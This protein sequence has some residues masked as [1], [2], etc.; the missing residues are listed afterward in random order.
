[1]PLLAT[2]DVFT[3]AE[4]LG[5]LKAHE[6]TGHLHVRTG[7]MSANL[8][9]E[10]GWLVGVDLGDRVTGGGDD[11]MDAVLEICCEL[12]DS[13][14]GVSEFTPS[15]ATSPNG[16]RFDTDALLDSAR[17]RLE[18]W[19][20]I[21]AAIPS[22]ELKPRLATTLPSQTITLDQGRWQLILAVDGRRS[23]ASI[24]RAVGL[25]S[26]ELRRRMKALVDDRIIELDPALPRVPF[27][28][29]AVRGDQPPAEQ[30]QVGS[31]EEPPAGEPPADSKTARRRSWRRRRKDEA[32]GETPEVAEGTR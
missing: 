26:Y 20:S 25:T 13:H 16:V 17:G 1:M 22:V 9:L 23:V 11:A 18:E 7:A 2:F 29:E 21:R 12:L 14:R 15:A 6:C 24:A 28:G 3:F 32:S 30:N 8:V 4:F 10:A 31:A 27:D 19:R 5:L